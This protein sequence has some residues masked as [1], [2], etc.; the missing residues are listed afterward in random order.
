MTEQ[1]ILVNFVHFR[2]HTPPK[3]LK[4]ENFS[5]RATFSQ[6]MPAVKE[7]WFLAVVLL[8][9]RVPAF[10]VPS[11]ESPLRTPPSQNPLKP[12][13]RHILRTPLSTFSKP[14][15]PNLPF[16]FGFPCICPFQGIPAILS[17]CPS[18]FLRILEVR[19]A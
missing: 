2:Q 12:T 16:L 14:V 19:Q 15:F 11:R 3:T 17:V 10:Q 18:F 13:A 5:V 1:Q 4:L 7:K 9:R 6:K 8:K